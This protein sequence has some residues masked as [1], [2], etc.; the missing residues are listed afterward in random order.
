MTILCDAPRPVKSARS[1]PQYRGRMTRLEMDQWAIDS[2]R[3]ADLGRVSLCRGCQLLGAFPADTPIEN[4]LAAVALAF[5]NPSAFAALGWPRCFHP[6]WRW[7]TDRE[8]V[9]LWLAGRLVALIT[10]GPDG[11]A[12]VTR[13]DRPAAK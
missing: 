2:I 4:V 1:A 13:F 3:A 10:Q 12:V 11:S 9:S 6:A 8:D 5:V 7:E